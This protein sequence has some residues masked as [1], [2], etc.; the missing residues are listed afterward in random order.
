VL[1]VEWEFVGVLLWLGVLGTAVNFC[2]WFWMLAHYNASSLGGYSFL[3]VAIALVSSILIFGETVS[4]IQA[5]GVAV[6]LSA[7]IWSAKLDSEGKM[8]FKD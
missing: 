4:P 6:I 5:V 2:I 3:S 7:S 1:Y 8:R